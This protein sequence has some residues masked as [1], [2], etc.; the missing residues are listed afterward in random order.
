[1]FHLETSGASDFL[2]LFETVQDIA[3]L[4][5]ST[6]PTTINIYQVKKQDRGE[7]KW[8]RLT[9]LPTPGAK[10]KKVDARK[11]KESPIGKLY[12]S[13]IAF[14]DLKSSGTFLSNSGC[15]LP[16]ED[17]GNSATSVTCD[18]SK[19]K[20]DHL[21]LLQSGLANLAIPG[22][23]APDPALIYV[24]K[25]PIHPDAPA[26]HLHGI[27][28][29]FLA[30]RSPTHAGQA[31]SLIDA[32]LA[33]V[34]PLGAKTDKCSTF[35]E[36][37]EQRG[38]SKEQFLSALGSLETVPD[39]ATLAGKWIDQ[40]TSEGAIDFLQATNIRL[41]I[42]S[43]FKRQVLGG[44]DSRSQPLINDCDKWLETNTPGATLSK[45]FTDAENHLAKLHP[46]VSK[47]ELTA[48]ILLRAVKK[49]AD[50]A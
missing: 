13:V 41:K 33:E 29:G 35:E 39:L 25:T 4:N 7:W 8:G 10:Q 24:E 11:F 23:P 15:D 27:A 34:G 42:A 45:F 43:I 20:A 28:V 31:K 16:L 12:A 47:A 22:L 14:K 30:T 38:Y 37:R 26:T 9:N 44:V 40:L 36:L 6:T 17:G 18:L 2:F 32:L 3:E 49:C 48:N 19:L 1:M 5:H 46:L 50:Q 21:K